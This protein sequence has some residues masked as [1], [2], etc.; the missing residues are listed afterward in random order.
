MGDGFQ[1]VRETGSISSGTA[2][3]VIDGPH[4]DPGTRSDAQF[5]HDVVDMTTNRALADGQLTRDFP[6][7]EALRK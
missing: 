4:R 5:R 3:A 2:Q 1:S 6:V 7:S